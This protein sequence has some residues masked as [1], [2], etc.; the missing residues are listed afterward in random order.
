MSHNGGGGLQGGVG[1]QQHKLLLVAN[2]VQESVAHNGQEEAAALGVR[3]SKSTLGP[4]DSL[5]EIRDRT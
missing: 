1:Q 4:K 5:S 3:E 2:H